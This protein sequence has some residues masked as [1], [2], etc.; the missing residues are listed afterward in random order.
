MP[1][2]PGMFGAAKQKEGVIGVALNGVPFEPGTAECYGRSRGQRGSM[3]DCEWREEAIVNVKGRL[4]LDQ[5]NAHVQP[6]GAYHY[7]GI[8][9]GLLKKQLE[10]YVLGYAADGFPMV[11]AH[12]R[13]KPSWC[14]KSGIRPSGPG[15][16]YDGTYTQDFEFVAGS[17]DLDECN[18]IEV[19]GGVHLC[20]YG[21]FPIFA[22]LL[23]RLCRS[24]L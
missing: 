8:P 11:F 12:A 10:P 24:K 20:D 9:L 17:G 14:L 13:Y 21:S 18:G 19:D 22:A 5:H 4:G 23:K 1:L 16:R 3:G 7:H 2:N 15:G 6:T